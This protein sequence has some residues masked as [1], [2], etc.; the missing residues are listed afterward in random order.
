VDCS[1]VCGTNGGLPVKC[2]SNVLTAEHPTRGPL[3]ASFDAS[4]HHITGEVRDSRFG[5]RLAP[6]R[7][8]AQAEA[9]LVEAGCKLDRVSA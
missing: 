2:N 5:A 6:F 7:S 8:R 3:W 4:V 1:A 9:A